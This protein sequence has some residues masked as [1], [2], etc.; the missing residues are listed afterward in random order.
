[1]IIVTD[2]D[3]IAKRAVEIAT[4]NIGG[5]C[6]SDSSGN[7]TV[8]TGKEIIRLIKT[9]KHD[10]VVIMLDDNGDIGMGEGEK[11]LLEIYKDEDIKILGVIAVAS[12][13]HYAKGTKIHFSVTGSGEI[14][15]SVVNKYGQKTKK[16]VLKG[17]TVD[18]LRELDIYPIIGIGDPGKMMGKDD[19]I[20]GAPI[21]TK[22]MEII[23]S[24]HHDEKQWHSTDSNNRTNKNK[25]S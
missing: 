3:R 5:R 13:T 12:N 24:S 9:A 10:P 2:G 23:L 7:P 25:R 8:L 6:I 22:A 19:W 18:I 14:S 20:M 11:A 4:S 1:M 15:K 21:L 17:D 16:K